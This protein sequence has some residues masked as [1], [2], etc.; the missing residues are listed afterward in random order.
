MAMAFVWRFWLTIASRIP[1]VRAL[2]RRCVLVKL[3]RWNVTWLGF[4]RQDTAIA[5]D[6]GEA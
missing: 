6:F 1:I 2:E 4:C 5:A 3:N